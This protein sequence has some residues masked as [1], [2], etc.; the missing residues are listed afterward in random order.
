MLAALPQ[1]AERERTALALVA[2][3]G[4]ARP[5]VAQRLGIDEEQLADSLAQ[6]RKALRRTVA[7]LS[8]S[9]WCERAERL[10]SDRID[11]PLEQRDADR[12][13]VHLRNC[14][15]CVEHERRLVQA[16]DALIAGVAPAP[17]APVLLPAA[18][19]PQLA[20]VEPKPDP[21]KD[22]PAPRSSRELANAIGWN[23]LL[24]VAIVL[25]LAALALALAGALG[26]QL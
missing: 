9:G 24:I 22:L 11:G 17:S 23:A 4:T 15:R 3:A 1:L 10:I 7:P 8:G 14:P 18:S 13:D 21:T 12:L 16:T 6:A 2:V 20:A 19:P 26:A 25:A 5:A